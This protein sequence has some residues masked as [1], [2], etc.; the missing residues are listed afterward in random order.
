MADLPWTTHYL[1]RPIELMDDY[2]EENSNRVQLHK[3]F[4]KTP[5]KY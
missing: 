2:L 3:L 5:L 4:L 1:N